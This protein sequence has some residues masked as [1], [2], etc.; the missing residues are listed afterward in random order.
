L[1]KSLLIAVGGNS[2]IRAGERGTVAQQF[3]NARVTAEAV[4]A[5]AARGYHIVITHGNGPQVGAQ[6]LRSEIGSSQTYGLPLD[7]CVAMTQGE[8]GYVLENSLHSALADRG[9][10]TP[11]AVVITKVLVHKD[12]PAFKRPT[13]PIGPF[14]SREVAERKKAELGW[15]VVEDA[16]R[17]FRRVVPSPKPFGIVGLEV[18]RECL[19]KEFIVIAAGGGGI[20]VLGDGNSIQGVEAVVDKDWVSGLLAKELQIERLAISTD[21]EYVCLYYKKPEQEAISRTTIQTAKWYLAQG[22][23]AEGSMKPKIETAIDFLESGGLEVIITDPQHL[24]DA[25]E[26][27]AGTRITS[28]ELP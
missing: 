4:A 24:V 13:K 26:G 12:D 9:L 18:I 27:N 20:P 6:L 23:F 14:Y 1:K 25:V 11:I 28:K 19:E 22:H 5:L 21:V 10:Q 16:A 17:G 2:L 8:I 15:D 3:A 7:I